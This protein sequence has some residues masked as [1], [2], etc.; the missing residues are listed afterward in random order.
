MA[1]RLQIARARAR[2]ALA[3]KTGEQLSAEV[4]ARA[5][6]EFGVAN[7]EVASRLPKR[8]ATG[9]VGVVT[10]RVRVALSALSGR[11]PSE[12]VVDEAALQPARAEAPSG[13]WKHS[14]LLSSTARPIGGLRDP[15]YQSLAGVYARGRDFGPGHQLRRDSAGR[16]LTPEEEDALI[17]GKTITR[18]SL[19]RAKAAVNHGDLDAMQFCSRQPGLVAT[20][21]SLEVEDWLG[22]GSAK[23]VWMLSVGELF[24]FVAADELRY[25]TW[26]FCDDEQ[27]ILPHLS[28]LTP[29][30]DGMHPASILRFMTTPRD[31]L[32]LEGEPASPVDWLLRGGDVQ[33]LVEILETQLMS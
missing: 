30:F 11:S 9:R 7:E 26:Q 5:A 23:R 6:L 12:G 20:I 27:R 2:V 8:P 13:W 28:R 22:I 31:R 15:D 3:R 24:A 17:D 4:L 29:A 25:P 33:K 16:Q 14:P 21:S 32:R 18:E 1:T 10:A 19:E